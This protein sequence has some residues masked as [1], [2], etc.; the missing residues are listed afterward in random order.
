[1]YPA[2]RLVLIIAFTCLL[3]E[4]IEIIA[5]TH[6]NAGLNILFTE[7]DMN[8]YWNSSFGVFVGL[9]VPVY[10]SF[11]YEA[12]ASINSFESVSDDFPDFKLLLLRGGGN[13][14]ILNSDR[15]S[16]SLSGGI[17]LLLFMF[18]ARNPAHNRGNE[19]ESEFGFYAFLNM[20]CK[21]YN[22][23]YFTLSAG[24]TGSFTEPQTIDINIMQA[25]L[26]AAF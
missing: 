26:G 5:Q 1:M 16:F 17:S 18:E 13:I 15:I 7:G 4:K 22:G 6:A 19:E 14:L 21:I 8:K 23:I 2:L 10:K 11:G 3:S 25:G 24:R 12:I 20:S 9:N